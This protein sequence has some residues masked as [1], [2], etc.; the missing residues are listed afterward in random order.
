MELPE[1]PFPPMLAAYMEK[2]PRT[3][4]MANASAAAE[5]TVLYF[6]VSRRF[7]R[8]PVQEQGCVEW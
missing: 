6:I 3:V 7:V 4:G 8:S 1:I 5:H 2:S